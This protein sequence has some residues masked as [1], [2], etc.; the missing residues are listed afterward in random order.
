MA[1]TKAAD[2]VEALLSALAGWPSGDLALAVSGGL[3]SMVLLDTVAATRGHHRR[4]VRVLH[5]DHGLHPDSRRWAEQVVATAE[6]FDLP[7]RTLQVEVAVGSGEGLEAAARRARYDAL[8]ASLAPGEILLTAHHANDQAETVLL[9]LMRGAGVEG[10]AAIRPLRPFARGWLGRPWLAVPRAAILARAE[11]CALAWIDDPA[12]ERLEHD[13]TFI[14]H[15]ILPRLEDRWPHAIQAI[16]ASARHL[17]EIAER[18]AATDRADLATLARPDAQGALDLDALATMPAPRRDALLRRL[19]LDRGL[20]PPDRRALAEIA[21]Q[22]EHARPD[23]ETEVRW[24]DVE[25]HAW[26]GRLHVAR[27]QP[28]LPPDF[29]ARWDGLAPHVLPPGLGCVAIEPP[30]AG[31]FRLTARRGGERILLGANRP[32]QSVKHALQDAGVPPWLRRRAP[33]LWHG[34]ALWAVGDWLLAAPFRDFLDAG[35]AAWRWH[36]GA[37]AAAGGDR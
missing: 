20:A 7:V 18:E 13:R 24:E 15:E 8:A 26:R 21:R 25:A 37:L 4:D 34:D 9:R 16:G 29:E 36:R 28:E 30:R 31:D 1:P 27:R 35:A 2:P 6:A 19:C 11:Q 22:I 3:D 33:L 23:A 10:L 12:N 5:V 14:R 17:G 32:S